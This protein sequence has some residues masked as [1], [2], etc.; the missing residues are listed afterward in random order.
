MSKIKIAHLSDLH[1]DSTEEWTK[2]ITRVINCITEKKPNLIVITGDC[3]D[4]PKDKDF[5]TLI[6]SIESL[7]QKYKDDNHALHIITIPGNHDYYKYGNSFFTSNKKCDLY[8]KHSSAL[9]YPDDS[10]VEV[11][12]SFFSLHKIAI[13]PFDSNNIK[14]FGFAQGRINEPEKLLNNISDKYKNI[15]NDKGFSYQSCLKIV[16][17]HHHPLPLPTPRR[18]EKIEPLMLFQNAYQFLDIITDY[19]IN[20]LLHGHKHVSGIAEYNTLTQGSHPILVSACAS[21]ASPKENEREIKIIDVSESGTC[22][23]SKLTADNRIPVFKH[24]SSFDAQLTRYSTVRRRRY[25]NEELFPKPYESTIKHITSKTK[26][27]EINNDGSAD[28]TSYYEEIEWKDDVG[29]QEKEI[30]EYIRADYGRVFGGTKEFASK[31]LRST[32]NS[33]GWTHPH[34]GEFEYTKPNEPEEYPISI[35][36]RHFVTKGSSGYCLIKYPLIN[37]F[38]LTSRELDEKYLSGSEGNLNEEVCSVEVNYPTK[39]L[40]LTVTFPGKEYFPEFVD[41]N[42]AKKA[43]LVSSPNINVLNKIYDI[44]DDETGFLLNNNALRINPEFNQISLRIK[45]PQPDLLYILRWSLPADPYSAK[46]TN[47]QE[48]K[49]TNLRKV[50][51]D[52]ESK[53]VETFYDKIVKDLGS[54]FSED[55]V[56]F[57]LLGYDYTKKLLQAT[58]ASSK[59][60]KFYNCLPLL[61]GRGPAGKAFKMGRTEYYEKGFGFIDEDGNPLTHVEIVFEGFDPMAVLSIPLMYPK[62]VKK[63]WELL[64]E[65]GKEGKCPVFAVLSIIT[66]KEDPRFALFKKASPETKDFEDS[67]DNKSIADDEKGAVMEQIYNIISDKFNECFD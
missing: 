28:I 2:N 61:V 55:G 31:H 24:A 54:V 29:F 49:L 66:N 38:A 41:V 26:L 5:K 59:S 8:D 67:D 7:C 32:E 50:F 22:H 36:P 3:V 60:S 30:N 13:F 51:L 27:A 64:K 52:R 44:H 4:S 65:M 14:S 35:K 40:E 1:C 12:E 16:L 21:S 19:D 57:V 17:T 20:L 10:A 18:E 43:S 56:E 6:A 47:G 58:K 63:E 62:I 42:A 15:A 9:C 53:E 11:A 33:R 39:C 37:G 23:V 46:L 45:Y 48:R 25:L 34:Y